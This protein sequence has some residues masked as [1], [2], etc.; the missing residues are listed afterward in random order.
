MTT[1]HDDTDDT[2]EAPSDDD[3]APTDG[4]SAA[5]T[6]GGG[7]A[8]EPRPI[9]PAAPEEFGLV[10]VWWGDGKGKTTAAM[11]MGFRAA[12]HG[13]RVHMLQ[14]MKGGADSVEGVRGEYNAIAAVPGF[15]YENAGHYG[16]HGLLDGSA[17]DEHEAKATAAFERA[18]ALVA[19]A[20]DADLTDPLPLDGEPED[21]VHMLIFDELLYAAD[22]GLVDPDDVVRLVES[23]PDDL[24][25]VLTGSH[26]EP[27]YLDGVADLITNV[28][29][30]AHPFDDGQRARRGTEY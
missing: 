12:G 30:V 6:P 18:E 26:A 22:R 13:Y 7:A 16:W 2:D 3:R 5:R 19:G 1:T 14:F 8:P 17:D 21:G 27:E 4:D 11:G 20:A 28:R 9:E 15:S 10:Q 23:K 25:L 29:K 24:E